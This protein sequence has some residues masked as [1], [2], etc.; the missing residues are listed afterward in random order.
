MVYVAVLV[1]VKVPHVI[2]SLECHRA[3]E[4]GTVGVFGAGLL[5]VDLAS[6]C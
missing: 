2:D 4:G 3:N 1:A 5:V 6:I